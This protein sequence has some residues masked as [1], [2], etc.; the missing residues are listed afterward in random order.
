MPLNH[1]LQPPLFEF[2]GERSAGEGRCNRG[3]AREH[4]GRGDPGTG[5]RR[6]DV[7]A[8]TEPVGGVGVA[9]V[10][11]DLA[12]VELGEK[13]GLAPIERGTFSS[14]LT[15]PS[16]CGNTNG[17]PWFGRLNGVARLTH[18]IQR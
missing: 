7:G 1:A 4:L 12:T 5:D 10:I 9:S 16:G 13:R 8:T 14:V 17:S 18:G 2:D 3:K 6:G 11:G 15:V